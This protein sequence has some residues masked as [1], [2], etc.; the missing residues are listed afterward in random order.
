MNVTRANMELKWLSNQHRP[1]W[2]GHIERGDP[3]S[4]QQMLQWLADGI[5]EAVK[6]PNV[7]YVITNKGRKFL[8]Q[9]LGAQS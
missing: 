7:G 8:A 6:Q 3:I 9:R 4:D 1:V 2:G 5:I